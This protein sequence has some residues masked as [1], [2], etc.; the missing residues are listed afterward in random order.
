MSRKEKKYHFIYKTTNLLN[1]KFYIGMHSTNDLNDG[2]I[3]SG[4]RLRYSIRKYGKENFKFEI[5]EWC[6]DRDSLIK[7]EKEIITEEHVNNE[8]CYNL[9]F[10]GSGGGKFYSP[11]HQFKCSQA[12]GIKHRERM[13]NDIEYRNNFS[14][15]IS[16]SNKLRHQRGDVKKI[17]ESYSWIGKKHK[18]ETIEKMKESKKGQGI[19]IANSQYG[20][21]W[22][23]NGNENKKI[24]KDVELPQDW[25]YG[26]SK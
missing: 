18:T 26:V 9:K 5:I 6:D 11:E 20:T 8:N 23:T 13:I 10:G 22:I 3:G 16:E 17:Q 4:T 25:W 19:G 1:N 15:K 14:K 21:K 12:A 24:K 2:Y 7:R